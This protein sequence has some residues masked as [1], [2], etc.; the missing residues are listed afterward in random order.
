HATGPRAEKPFVAINCTAIPEGLLDSELFGQAS[1]T[2][3]KKRGLFLEA[4]GGS[5]FL[6]EIG[7]LSPPLQ[8]K[9]LR[10]LQDRLICPVGDSQPIEVDVR[11]LAATHKDLK[12]AIRE[13]RFREDLFLRLS[14][15][16]LGM[17]ALRE[18]EEDI[19][20]LAEHFL[21]KYSA[22]NNRAIKGFIGSKFLDLIKHLPFCKDRQ[23]RSF[24]GFHTAFHIL[25]SVGC[26]G[27]ASRKCQCWGYRIS[28]VNAPSEVTLQS[29]QRYQPQQ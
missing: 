27:S 21:R 11:I 17:P 20:I 7:D 3:N 14:V 2:S 15:I 26:F 23:S 13:G 24:L 1:G 8:A 29:L 18:R 6:D 12:A 28:A 10:A 16:P 22:A 19:P 5:L 4:E 25:C 9:L